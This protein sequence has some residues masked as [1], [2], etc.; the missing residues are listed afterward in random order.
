[1]IDDSVAMTPFYLL[2]GKH[3]Q[4]GNQDTLSSVSAERTPLPQGSVAIKEVCSSALCRLLSGVDVFVIVLLVKIKIK[5]SPLCL[6]W[7]IG[8]EM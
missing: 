3:R 4:Q 2:L 1:M 6:S 8:T 5:K 7:F